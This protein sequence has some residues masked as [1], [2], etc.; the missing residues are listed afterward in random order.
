MI[1]VEGAEEL[2]QRLT[3]LEQMQRV[4]DAIYAASL[5]LK[6]KVAEYPTRSSRPNMM[7]RGNS[8]KA[9]RMRR[10]FFYHLKHGNI[11]VPYRRG[12]S[13][14]SE[15]LGQRWAVS[16]ENRGWRGV[17]GNNASYARLVQDSQK[18]TSYHRHT[19]W[20]TTRQVELMYGRQAINKIEQALRQEVE[21]G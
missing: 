3:R 12:M 2:I 11:E 9:Q 16:M 7:L 8:A 6:G 10:G 21:N 4:R 13:P 19:G 18:Q 14:N 5:F 1:R 15:K 20:I 17:V